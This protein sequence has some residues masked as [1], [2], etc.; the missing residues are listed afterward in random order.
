MPRTRSL[1]WAEL[2]IGLVS[3]FAVVMATV[4]I[5]LLSGSGGFFWQRYSL[6]TTFANIAGLKEGAPVRVAGVEVGSVSEV[7]LIGDQVEVVMGVNERHKLR[8]T[9]ASI[10][11]LGSVSLLG[12]A[13][14]DITAAS[15]GTPIPEWGYVRSGRA[16][17]TIGDVATQAST[18]IE[19]T[20][21]LIADLRSG[22]GTMGQLLTDERLYNE[23]T[24]LVVAM[25]GVTDSITKGGGTMSRLLNDPA[26]A[27]ALEAS[28]NNLEAVTARIRAGE[29][30]LGK[31]LNDDALSQ[32][33]TSMSSNLE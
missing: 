16:T 21:A 22:R 33:L 17:G 3:I 4:L 14:L 26:A 20:T 13:A 11:S 23:L 18:A 5:F 19:E 15:D 8:I 28:L 24:S 25:H 6:K 7:N 1:A 9:S 29:G 10:A 27:K 2:K 12:E 32:S 31:L 30:S